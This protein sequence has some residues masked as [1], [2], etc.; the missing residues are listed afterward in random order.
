[1]VPSVYFIDSTSG[2]DLEI[3]GGKVMGARHTVPEL[4]HLNVLNEPRLG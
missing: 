1:M 3:T 4:V 2:V